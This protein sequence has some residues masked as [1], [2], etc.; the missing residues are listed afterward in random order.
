MLLWC[1]GRQCSSLL[2]ERQTQVQSLLW[3]GPITVRQILRQ[4]SVDHPDVLERHREG[5]TFTRIRTAVRRKVP[6][7]WYKVNVHSLKL[8]LVIIKAEECAL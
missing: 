1:L 6:R 5:C 8:A 2:Q 4:D 3:D 7:R